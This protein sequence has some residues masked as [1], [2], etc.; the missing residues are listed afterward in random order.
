MAISFNLKKTGRQTRYPLE[1]SKIAANAT[2]HEE[3]SLS[4]CPSCWE[5]QTLSLLGFYMI[6]LRK[7]L[8]S[9]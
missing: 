8:D 7:C 1:S 3:C 5:K 9:L 2:K 4:T 6:L